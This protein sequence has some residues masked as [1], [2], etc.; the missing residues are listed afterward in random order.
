MTI[1]SSN[2]AAIFWRFEDDDIVHPKDSL[3]YIIKK[4]TSN[5]VI[6]IKHLLTDESSDIASSFKE[7]YDDVLK[8]RL[9][10]LN[11]IN[12]SKLNID[13]LFQFISDRFEN[14]D[15][16][17]QYDLLNENVLFAIRTTSMIAQNISTNKN[18][19]NIIETVNDLSNR[20]ELNNSPSDEKPYTNLVRAVKL[21]SQQLPNDS[22]VQ[23]MI[24]IQN[25]IAVELGIFSSDIIFDDFK[26][27][28][29]SSSKIEELNEILV[30]ASQM[31]SAVAR[32]MGL[33]EK[34]GKRRSDPISI[35]TNKEDNFLAN[36][37]IKE[38]YDNI[39]SN[40]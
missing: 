14:R 13:D 23:L 40:E 24:L 3:D 35:R 25:S 34:R 4:D 12:Q 20:I 2:I 19:S 16:P 18:S 38:F 21:I 36:L 15:L 6:S 10:S 17:E 31:Y 37:G 39:E 22:L 32:E 27:S 29:I 5:L 33:I 8:L 11:W 28:R 1:Q 7:L 30:E 9:D 26:N